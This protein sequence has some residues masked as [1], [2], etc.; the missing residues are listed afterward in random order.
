VKRFFGVAP[1]LGMW[2]DYILLND[3]VIVAASTEEKP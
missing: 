1:G 3:L 2:E